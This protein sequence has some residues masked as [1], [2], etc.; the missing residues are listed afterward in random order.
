MNTLSN[1]WTI[2]IW[3][4]LAVSLLLSCKSD[5]KERTSSAGSNNSCQIDDKKVPFIDVAEWVINWGNLWADQLGEEHAQYGSW[6]EYF[7]TDMSTFVD[8]ITDY[9]RFRVYYG[10][11]PNSDQTELYPTLLLAPIDENCNRIQQSCIYKFDSSPNN[12]TA[13]TCDGEDYLISITEAEEW[14]DA[15][16]GGFGISEENSIIDPFNT[17]KFFVPLALNY[18][19]DSFLLNFDSN[20]SN[21][22]A[23]PVL[24]PA[25]SSETSY[26]Y[27]FKIVY[28]GA[29]AFTPPQGGAVDY[30]DFAAP[31][32]R[33]C[34]NSTDVLLG[35]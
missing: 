5:K 23:F 20:A 28:G 34:G 14:A 4:L 35:N 10:I 29:S 33:L 11:C 3:G 16:R 13:N 6:G 12:C 32:P 27:S 26:D 18:K 8:F 19:T 24:E 9:D 25:P 30:I 21:L 2:G 22:Y 1:S 31:C 7:T 15:F 17:N